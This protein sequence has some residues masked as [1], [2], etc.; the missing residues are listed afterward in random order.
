M[1]TKIALAI[2][3][4]TLITTTAIAVP[5]PQKNKLG[6]PYLAVQG[7]YGGVLS[8]TE[9][10]PDN[11][12]LGYET[13]VGAYSYRLS[14]GY[15]FNINQQLQ[16]GPELGY[17]GYGSSNYSI[18]TGNNS[19]TRVL[20][21]DGYTI[22]A[23]AN[24]TYHFTPHWSVSGKLGVAAVH[25]TLDDNIFDKT[26]KK[27]K[28]LAEVGLEAGYD[29]TDMFGINWGFLSTIGGKTINPLGNAIV[30]DTGTTVE[31]KPNEVANVGS[32]FVGLDLEF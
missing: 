5:A 18:Q 22:D 26:F 9:G 28:A 31:V 27:N 24:I 11:S 25:Q 8:G 4:A 19:Y 1:K 21:Y 17:N 14:A 13:D 10:L 3:L 16:I 7:G 32:L 30:S 20:S 6:V 12:G 23:L 2:T 15:L 29:F